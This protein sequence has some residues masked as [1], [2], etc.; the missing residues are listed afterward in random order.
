[1]LRLP[2]SPF[3]PV[4]YMALVMDAPAFE[5]EAQESFMKQTWRNRFDVRGANNV[6]TLTFP[7]NAKG[8]VKPLTARVTLR[9]GDWLRE[10]RRTLEAAYNSSPF[11]EHYLPEVLD[12]IAPRQEKLMQYNRR[13]LDWVLQEVQW[14]GQVSETTEFEVPPKDG[15]RTWFRRSKWLHLPCLEYAQSFE[16]R[17]PF[18]PHLSVLDVM[19]NLGPETGA[20]LRQVSSALPAFPK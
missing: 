15:M 17:R 9:E 8:A 1:M 5:L 10:H 6:Q 18:D 7:V 16:E 13:L 14:T 3:P 11:G 20:Y 12:L 19:M 2:T 4:V